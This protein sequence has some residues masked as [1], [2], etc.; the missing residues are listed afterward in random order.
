M[1]HKVVL[2]VSQ[3]EFRQ[4]L[5]DAA[6]ARYERGQGMAYPDPGAQIEVAQGSNGSDIVIRWVD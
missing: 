4:M 3:E 6:Q 5:E 1:I 2:T